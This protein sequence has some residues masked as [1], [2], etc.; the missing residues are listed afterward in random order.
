MKIPLAALVLALPLTA[1]AGRLETRVPFAPGGLLEVRLETG[2]SVE[3]RAGAADAVEL[4]A[5]RTPREESECE[6][7]LEATPGGARLSSRYRGSASSRSSSMRFT[8]RVPARCDLSLRSAGGGLVV[9]GVEGTFTGETAGGSIVLVDVKGRARLSTLGGPVR[10]SRSTLE[11]SVSTNGGDVRIEGVRG[12][13]HATTLAGSVSHDDA[14]DGAGGAAG[15]L[16]I[17]SMGGDIDVPDAP[18]GAQ[19]KTMG[20]AIRVA[21]AGGPVRA[22]TMGGDVTIS[23]AG[24]DVTALSHAGDVKVTLTGD[25]RDVRLESYSGGVTLVAP[26]RLDASIEVELAYTRDS[27]RRYRVE[28]DVPLETTT[29]SEWDTSH[30]SPRKFVRARGL[31]GAGRGRVVVR[32]VN[33][34]V[35]IATAR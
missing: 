2:G 30:G 6:V 8:L 7:A 10:V 15:G 25:A 12:G 20:G 18:H 1:R 13:L 23:T 26:A 21:A 14:P 19:L 3:V 16:R 27:A 32:T 17:S 22:E 9:E 31:A 11:G 33:G 5:D 34:N 35:R 24:G 28:S 4:V 29:T